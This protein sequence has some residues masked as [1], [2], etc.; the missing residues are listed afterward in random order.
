MAM[1][2]SRRE[3]SELKQRR[4]AKSGPVESRSREA[5]EVEER[6]Y[7]IERAHHEH[8]AAVARRRRTLEGF[9]PTSQ[10]AL[11]KVETSIDELPQLS[12]A[13]RKR[14]V[15]FAGLSSSRVR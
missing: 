11:K 5:I 3:R 2:S 15:T 7:R 6:I 9:M 4:E 1:V 12:R 10:T 13:Q 8:A 14:A